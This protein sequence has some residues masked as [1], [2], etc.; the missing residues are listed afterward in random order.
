MDSTMTICGSIATCV[1]KTAEICQ[2]CVKGTETSNND[3]AIV[4]I[5]CGTIL[6][7]AIIAV[8]AYLIQKYNERK[9]NMNTSIR[10]REYEE[11]DR[12][13]KQRAELLNKLLN[14]EETLMKKE[15]A[16]KLEENAC[17]RYIKELKNLITK[18]TL[19]EN[20]QET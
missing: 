17:K 11:K 4:V 3:V 8:I 14:V 5:I 1:N 16:Y 7:L 9:A 19:S 2:P 13:Y 20:D 12:E 6:L 10:N 18:N 15:S